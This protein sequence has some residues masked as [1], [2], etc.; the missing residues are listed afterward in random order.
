MMMCQLSTRKALKVFNLDLQAA[1]L[2]LGV[3]YALWYG[4]LLVLQCYIG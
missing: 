1:G 3:T 2:E 4:P